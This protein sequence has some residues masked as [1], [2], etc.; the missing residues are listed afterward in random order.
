MFADSL[1]GFFCLFLFS[2]VTFRGTLDDSRLKGKARS[3]GR[4]LPDNKRRLSRMTSCGLPAN[5]V[6]K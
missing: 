4:A 3:R 5:L 6:G 1:V 2:S